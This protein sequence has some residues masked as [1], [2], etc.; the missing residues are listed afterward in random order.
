MFSDN[1]DP[2]KNVK[3]EY[4]DLR[5]GDTIRVKKDIFISDKYNLKEN[6]VVEVDYDEGLEILWFSTGSKIWDTASI[7][8]IKEDLDISRECYLFQDY[9]LTEREY[10]LKTRRSK[11]TSVLENK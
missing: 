8:F 6:D 11:I 5:D 9:F 3:Q 7:V 4:L 2:Y 10:L 1:T